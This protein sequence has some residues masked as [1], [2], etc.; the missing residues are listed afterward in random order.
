MELPK[1]LKYKTK[2]GGGR[3]RP[4]TR[5]LVSRSSAR[6][7][8]EDKRVRK[9]VRGARRCSARPEAHPKKLGQLP[10]PKTAQRG[11]PGVTGPQRSRREEGRQVPGRREGRDGSRRPAPHPARATLQQ[12]DVQC[13]D[14]RGGAR[15]RAARGAAGLPSGPLASSRAPRPR[16]GTHPGP[17]AANSWRLP[18][19]QRRPGPRTPRVPV[20][21]SP[22]SSAFLPRGAASGAPAGSAARQPAADGGAGL[23][24]REL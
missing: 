21:P 10:T 6:G 15:A 7:A 4:R 2:V 23:C 3:R 13:R 9:G 1:V 14:P 11:A 22:R 18:R 5:P 17:L 8:F 20:G 12:P 24:P 16:R 19:R